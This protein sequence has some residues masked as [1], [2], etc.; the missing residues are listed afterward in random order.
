MTS[1]EGKIVFLSGCNLW[2][3]NYAPVDG[4]SPMS[5]WAVQN[6]HGGLKKNKRTGLEFWGQWKEEVDMKNSGRSRH[7]NMMKI[8]NAYV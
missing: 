2:E 6:E 7:V 1:R 3:A 5:M 4:L 8:Y